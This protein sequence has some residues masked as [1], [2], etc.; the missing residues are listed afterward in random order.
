MSGLT[1]STGQ[2]V[3][4]GLCGSRR[5]RVLFQRPR[6]APGRAVPGGGCAEEEAAEAFNATTDRFGAY[7]R[8]VRCR[9][10]GFVYTSPRPAAEAL[11]RSYGDCADEDY[12][13]EA[14]SRSINAHLS[15]STIKRFV[16]CGRLLE[17]GCA[18]G[19]FLNAARVDF[20]VAGLE[21]SAWACRIARERF[22]LDIH[23]EAIEGVQGFAPGVFD[24]VVMIDVIEHLSDPV[25]AVRRAAEWLRPGGVLYLVTPDIGSFSARVLGR[26]WWGL[27]PAHLHYFDRPAL[28]RALARA[29]LEP[30]WEKSFGRIFTYRYWA[31]RLRHYPAFLRRILTAGI[32]LCGA[33][34]KFLYLNTRDSMEVCARKAADREISKMDG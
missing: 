25:G 6:G 9:D 4:C 11:L 19:Y 34:D 18:A 32:R 31:S 21:P 23:G 2:E 29:G 1:S 22:R 28:R 17:V 14:S 20:E 3:P 13:K 15:L 27:R 16:P 24:V 8:V 7:G 26:Y 30:V 12:L 10:C 5:A 33:E